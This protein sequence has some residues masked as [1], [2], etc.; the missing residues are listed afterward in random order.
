MQLFHDLQV[1][2]FT[3][4]GAITAIVTHFLIN[5]EGIP[6]LL[7]LEKSCNAM[8]HKPLLIFLGLRPF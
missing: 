6:L 4:N 5:P 2:G 1:S 7:G 8:S 3:D